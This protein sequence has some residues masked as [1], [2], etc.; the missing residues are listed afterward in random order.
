MILSNVKNDMEE[1]TQVVQQVQNAE[2]DQLKAYV[3]QMM[4][5]LVPKLM[6]A[7]VRL[8][9]GLI[10]WILG[11]KAIKFFRKALR[12]FLERSGVDTGV[13]QFL[14]SFAKVALYFCL[15]MA[16]LGWLGI[17]TASVVA[18][19]G[20]AG[21]AVGM[22]L[23]GSLSNFAGGVLILVLKPFKVGDYIMEDSN[24]NEGTVKTIRMFYTELMTVDSRMVIIPNGV[25]ANSSLTNVTHQDK[26]RL[27]LYVGVSYESDIKVAKTVLRE[28]LEREER[29][30]PD[31]EPHVFV[32]SLGDSAVRMGCR[33]WV[34]TEDF[35][36]VKWDLTEQ[37]KITFDAVGIVIPYNQLEVT[38]KGLQP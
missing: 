22:A 30:L 21:L 32:D 31:E 18:I 14:D 1:L 2:P 33:L 19:L 36:Q 5:W 17:S 8:L 7:G 27:I 37:I 16:L 23:Q 29:R 28:L 4:E 38:V 10:M 13:R 26:R 34:R 20:S 12:R 35:W 6:D 24:K 9:I 3:E 25:L 11:V 15:G